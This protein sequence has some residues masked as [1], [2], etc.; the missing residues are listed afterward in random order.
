MATRRKTTETRTPMP[1]TKGL[2]GDVTHLLDTLAHPLRP[3]IEALRQLVLSAVPACREGVKWNAPSY[4]LDEWFLTF[5]L[6]H[7]DRV[8][9]V[10]HRG[11]K[12]GAAGTKPAIDDP[13]GLLA[14]RGVDRALVTLTAADARAR[15]A[16]LTA[17]LRAWVAAG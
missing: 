16:A 15:V 2:D 12:A 13:H 1:I 5:H 4:R 8:P 14:W 6:R 7:R 17:L 3:T 9:L 10:L 11:A